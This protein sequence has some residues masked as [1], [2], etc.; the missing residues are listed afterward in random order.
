[1]KSL[2]YDFY[3][4]CSGCFT[5]LYVGGIVGTSLGEIFNEIMSLRG[6]Y[7]PVKLKGVERD[8]FSNLECIEGG[9]YY[10]LSSSFC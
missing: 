9:N 8:S 1:M 5:G 10:S 7:T 4:V 2:I 3:L 6:D